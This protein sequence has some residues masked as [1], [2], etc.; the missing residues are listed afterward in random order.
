MGDNWIGWETDTAAVLNHLDLAQFPDIKNFTDA[1]LNA[2]IAHRYDDIVST[3]MSS[4]L[5]QNGYIATYLHPPTP[6]S[7]FNLF[8]TVQRNVR[9]LTGRGGRGR[10]KTR[11]G[12]RRRKTA[13]RR[14][15]TAGRRR[16]SRR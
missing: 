5:N 7:V 15:K 9:A 13:G 10:R 8:K 6:Q 12:G 2:L 3:L 1:Q 4:D 16:K 11:R 14:R